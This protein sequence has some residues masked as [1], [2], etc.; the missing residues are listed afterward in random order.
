MLGRPPA[1]LAPAQFALGLRGVEGQQVRLV[2]MFPVVEF[3]MRA[4]APQLGCQR[5][6][7]ADL[8]EAVAARS[9]VPLTLPE[10]ATSASTRVRY[11][12]RQSS[13]CRHGRTARGN[14]SSGA[15]PHA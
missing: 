12:L 8:D 5:G 15:W 3:P 14:R 6:D 7:S 9:E 10:A 13:T 4:P 1:A 2:W 11:P